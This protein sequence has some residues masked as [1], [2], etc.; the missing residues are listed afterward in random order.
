MAE[1]F[2]FLVS[3]PTSKY[4]S[5]NFIDFTTDIPGNI[6]LRWGNWEIGL[7]EI[8]FSKRRTVTPKIFICCDIIAPNII[9][10][11]TSQTLRYIPEKSGRVHM[12]YNPIFY[13]DVLPSSLNKIRIYIKGEDESVINSFLNVTLNCT[14]HLRQKRQYEVRTQ[15]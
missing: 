2:I 4:K 1:Q 13:F 7:A 3:K 9:A 10:G 5:N 11:K 15:D 14:V 12:I 6:D 8:S